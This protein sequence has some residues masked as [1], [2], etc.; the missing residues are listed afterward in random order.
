MSRDEA[1]EVL[2]RRVAIA[3]RLGT[4]VLLPQVVAKALLNEPEQGDIDGER[5]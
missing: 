4:E 3:E 5:S 2:A 1:L